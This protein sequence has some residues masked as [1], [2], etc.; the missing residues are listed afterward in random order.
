VANLRRYVGES[1]ASAG[2]PYKRRLWTVLRLRLAA[3]LRRQTALRP[4]PTI[5]A[6]AG[7]TWKYGM[8]AAAA[9]ALTLF[10]LGPWAASG[11][12]Q[13]PISQVFDFV[14]EHAG[15]QGVDEPPA[16]TGNCS[17]GEVSPQQAAERLGIPVGQ[18]SYLPAGFGL[19]SSTSSPNSTPGRGCTSW[20][21]PEGV[22]LIRSRPAPIHH[23]KSRPSPAP[24]KER[25]H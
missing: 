21:P 16:G 14:G 4:R 15:V 1:L 23:T 17:R 25:S 13:N 19:A 8:A 12:A 6:A 7:R 5:A 22:D 20:W 10:A 2:A 24:G 9:V 3:N 18:P 11:F